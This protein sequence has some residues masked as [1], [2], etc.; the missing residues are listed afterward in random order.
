M[1]SNES[2]LNHIGCL[3]ASLTHQGVK[4]DP[5]R[6]RSHTQTHTERLPCS[7][8]Q[9]APT[10]Q[11]DWVMQLLLKGQTQ[12][13]S[14]HSSVTGIQSAAV[15]VNNTDLLRLG[16]N[17]PLICWIGKIPLGVG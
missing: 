4:C 2:A 7:I 15:P 3:N 16:P 13:K 9:S 11:H 1:C 8:Q 5:T 6:A 17:V 14:S 12:A 10:V